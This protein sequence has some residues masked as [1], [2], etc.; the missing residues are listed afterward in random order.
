[1]RRCHHGVAWPSVLL[2]IL[3]CA[4]AHA[5]PGFYFQAHGP[6]GEASAYQALDMPCGAP[7][8]II[9]FVI[10]FEPTQD[11]SDFVALDMVVNAYSPFPDPHGAQQETPPFWRFDD[12]GCDAGALGTTFEH[13]ADLVGVI[14]PWIGGNPGSATGATHLSQGVERLAYIA[15]RVTPIPV[16]AGRRYFGGVITLPV[17]HAAACSGCSAGFTLDSYVAYARSASGTNDQQLAGNSRL[18]INLGGWC[19][20][21]VAAR[22]NPELDRGDVALI[23]RLKNA[24]PVTADNVCQ[25][26]SV[27]KHTWGSLKLLYR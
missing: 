8:S 16:Q 17:C 10:T 26:V 14:D 21:T 13:P 2:G 25:P 15:Y 24:P 7:D 5:Y 9:Q 11:L 6:Y 19:G 3:W 18:C 20:V 22:A 12:A 1:M 27:Q 23:E 4:S